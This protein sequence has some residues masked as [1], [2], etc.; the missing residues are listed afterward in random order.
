MAV[1][2]VIIVTG[3]IAV[4]CIYKR[5]ATKEGSTLLIMCVFNDAIVITTEANPVYEPG[6]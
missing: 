3:S 6:N 5:R 4:V 2:V 1:C